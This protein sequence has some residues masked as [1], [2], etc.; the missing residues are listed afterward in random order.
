MT[1]LGIRLR[2]P[3]NIEQGAPWEG[4][5]PV[6][7]HARFATFIAPE[8]GI[9]AI[10]RVLITYQDKRQAADGSRID[11][12]R[13]IIERWAPPSEND[14][15]SYAAHVRQRMGLEH[16]E[17]VDVKDFTTMYGLVAAIIRHENG[18]QP[19]DD[20]T[21]RKGL[22]LAGIVVPVRPVEKSRTLAGAKVAAGATVAGAAAEPVMEVAAQ[23]EP[24]LP[25]VQQAAYYGKWALVA[26][27]LGA[28]GYMAYRYL[29]DR[30]LRVA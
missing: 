1:S 15:T 17:V 4:L 10:A 19:Y 7:R 9:R 5:A 16:D 14:S 20:A 18:V 12:V 13:E 24:L 27:A 28:V 22:A 29:Q 11:T 2:N 3:G 26:L 23:I 8:F 6:Q 25:I 21:I 30:K